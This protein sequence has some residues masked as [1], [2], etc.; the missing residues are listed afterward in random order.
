MAAN[1]LQFTDTQKQ[2][3]TQNNMREGK[4]ETKNTE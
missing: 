2:G 1:L 4:K 3:C